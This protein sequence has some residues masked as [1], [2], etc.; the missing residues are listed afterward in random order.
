MTFQEAYRILD[1]AN[2][3]TLEEV[4]EA[5][6]IQVKAWHPDRFE[7]DAKMHRIGTAKMK[8]INEAYKFVKDNWSRRVMAHVPYASQR[9]D[10]P[11]GRS[12]KGTLR[13]KAGP[14]DIVTVIENETSMAK[15]NKVSVGAKRVH[16][17]LGDATITITLADRRSRE[18]KLKVGESGTIEFVH[19]FDG[20]S[21]RF[22]IRL[23]QVRQVY[24]SKRGMPFPLV[25]AAA[26]LA[27]TRIGA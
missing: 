21:A 6:S 2:P 20:K 5:Y 27:V 11:V 24:K 14:R 12:S 8:L 3:K 1:L 17:Y 7:G 18:V 13:E 15:R 9:A 25:Y 10:A 19:A 26:D 16:E 22:E 23:L 4:R